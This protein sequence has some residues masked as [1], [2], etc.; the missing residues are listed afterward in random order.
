MHRSVFLEPGKNNNEKLFFFSLLFWSNFTKNWPISRARLARF[1]SRDEL[2]RR[3]HL[4]T[5]PTRT[6]PQHGPSAWGEGQRGWRGGL[7][8]N[9]QFL[10]LFKKQLFYFYL[11]T[12]FLTKCALFKNFFSIFFLFSKKTPKIFILQ[13]KV[14]TWARGGGGGFLN[15]RVYS[16]SSY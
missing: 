8:E 12:T 4:A 7:K 11:H 5:T 14:P 3:D 1:V 13:G 6:I 15:N 9:F 2:T 10:P 16:P